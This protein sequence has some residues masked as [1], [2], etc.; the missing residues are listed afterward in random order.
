MKV[1][2]LGTEYELTLVPASELREFDGLCRTYGKTIQVRF[3]EDMLDENDTPEEKAARYKETLRHEIVH[4]F[5]F[6]SGREDL[7]GDEQLVDWIA[8]QFP[9]MMKVFKD[10]DAL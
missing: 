2:V 4:A 8:K 3:S 6:E 1:D 9:K 5:L 10:M 7:C